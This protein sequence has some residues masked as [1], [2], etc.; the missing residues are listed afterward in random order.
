[1]DDFI[2]NGHNRAISGSRSLFSWSVVSKV[3]W[4]RV[5][6]SIGKSARWR[7][8]QASRGDFVFRIDCRQLPTRCHR[9]KI[10]L[11]TISEGLF[12]QEFLLGSK[13]DSVANCF[14][15][16]SASLLTRAGT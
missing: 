6:A 8:L 3:A 14:H 5:V 10:I 11:D 9:S 2:E 15:K 13:A 7:S 4:P 12:A 1:M 16:R